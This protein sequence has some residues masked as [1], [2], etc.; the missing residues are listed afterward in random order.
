LLPLSRALEWEWGERWPELV[1]AHGQL[2][3]LGFAG[4]FVAG[5]AFRLMPRFSGRPLAYP[6][7]VVPVCALMGGGVTLRAL[8]TFLGNDVAHAIAFLLSATM[9][10]GGAIAFAAI[11]LRTLLHRASKAEATAWF[12]VLGAVALAGAASLQLWLTVVAID[13]GARL[14]PPAE[15]NALLSLELYG[16]LL[17][18]IGGVATRA[19]A[20]LAG[21]QRSQIAARVAAICLAGGAAAYALLAYL[22]ESRQLTTSMTRAMDAALLLVA[23]SLLLIVWASGIFHPR[24]NRVAP[25][26]Q[27]QFWFVRAACAWLVAS[28]LLLGW[29]AA[30][31]FVEKEPLD[32]FEVD[33]VRHMMTVGVVTMMIMGVAML[34][35]PEFAGR[36]LQHPREGWVVRS[37]FVCIN[38]AAALRVWPAMEGLGWLSSTRYWPMAVA[39]V[40]ALATIAAFAWM[41]TQSYMEQRRP[42]WALPQQGP[43]PD[44]G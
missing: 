31:A 17:M 13:D 1:Q 15:N 36:R 43:A 25:A 19:V 41:F 35:V 23:M 18:F 42:G 22:G 37:M 11:V 40:L 28:S 30:V 29:Y 21:R 32:Q 3:L 9:I 39:G 44:R 7:A 20:T 26:S 8:A 5:M 12:F 16:V 33:A 2:Q 34:V 14:L 27:E 6:A 10:L 38:A 24:A 4:L